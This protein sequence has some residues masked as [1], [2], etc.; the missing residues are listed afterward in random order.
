MVGEADVV[1]WTTV[2]V[3]VLTTVDETEELVVN[4]TDEITEVESVERGGG[5][6]RGSRDGMK[7]CSSDPTER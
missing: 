5:S 4:D 1:V 3:V 7:V 2:D 6:W